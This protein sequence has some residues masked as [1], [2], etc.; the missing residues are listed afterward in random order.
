MW[1]INQ[2]MGKHWDI[3]E[4]DDKKILLMSMKFEYTTSILNSRASQTW[5]GFLQTFS[6]LQEIHK[7][8]QFTH[9]SLL[10]CIISYEIL[11]SDKIWS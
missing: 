4:F 7:L 1:Y 2:K 10:M 11:A 8:I 5:C 9:S 6:R 3:I